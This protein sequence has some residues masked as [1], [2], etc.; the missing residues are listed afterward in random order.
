MQKKEVY[1]DIYLSK[2]HRIAV[3][4]SLLDFCYQPAGLLWCKTQDDGQNANEIGL[5][6]WIIST[7]I[8]SVL[9][10]LSFPYAPKTA[11]SRFEGTPS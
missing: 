5:K 2:L 1:S 11:I 9:H 8:F 10:S 7:N 3:I 6:R 4:I